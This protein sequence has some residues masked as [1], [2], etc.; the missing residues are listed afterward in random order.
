MGV[1]RHNWRVA[2]FIVLEDGRAYAASNSA[3]DTTL[4]AI[5]RE[6]SD[7]AL[8]QWLL[9]QQSSQVGTGMTCVDL[10]EVAPQHRP[11]L[12][13]AIRRPP[14]RQP[15]RRIPE[16]RVGTDRWQSWQGLFDDLNELLRRQDAGE[17]AAEFNPHMH[18]LIPQRGNASARDGSHDCSPSC[19][20]RQKS[21]VS[22]CRTVYSITPERGGLAAASWA[23]LL[24]HRGR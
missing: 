21:A 12:H 13:E 1:P 15:G 6:V 5:S 3:T 11:V 23:I 16:P 9:A 4:R 18:A 19:D 14:A 20:L 24:R 8:R 17:P 22:A 10:R 2:G 7:A